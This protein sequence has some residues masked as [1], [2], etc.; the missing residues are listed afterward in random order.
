MAAIASVHRISLNDVL[1]VNEAKA[2]FRS[3]TEGA[4]PYYDEDSLDGEQLPR[5]FRIDFV[6]TGP[7]HARMY[8]Q[9]RPLGDDLTDNAYEEDGYRFHDVMHL[10]NAACL[11]WSPVMRK[12]LKRK[13][14][15]SYETDEVEDGARAEIV[16]ELVVKAIHTEGKRLAPIDQRNEGRLFPEK[17][18]IT[19]GLIKTMLAYVEGLE[20]HN[21]Q[22]WQWRK[23]IFEGYRVYQRLREEGQGSVT[24]DLEDRSLS[25]DPRLRIGMAGIVRE[26]GGSTVVIGTV[27]ES[28]CWLAETELRENEDA[29]SQ[30]EVIAA[31]KGIVNALGFSETE[32]GSLRGEIA[33][34]RLDSGELSVKAVGQIRDVMW[35]KGIIEFKCTFNRVWDV[36]V[37]VVLG[38]GDPKDATS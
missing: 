14:K 1:R 38:L 29:S 13:R 7:K 16:E 36:V 34:S 20:V 30:A 2:N 28:M 26:L 19:F 25:F 23:A 37:C 5:E 33:L 11:R 21:S 10:A 27:Q 3:R 17:G 24:V 32:G 12:L 15:S 8:H 22:E 6:S 18:D 31:K 35:E 4:V 9:G